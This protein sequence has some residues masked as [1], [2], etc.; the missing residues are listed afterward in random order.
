MIHSDGWWFMM[1]G[2]ACMVAGGACMMAG[3]A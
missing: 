3:G 2:G 1:H